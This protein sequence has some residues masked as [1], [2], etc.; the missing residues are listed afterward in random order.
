T[1]SIIALYDN[2]GA[3]GKLSL[4]E[5]MLAAN[6]TANGSSPD[7]IEFNIPTSDTGYNK[8]GL[9]VFTI[10]PTSALPT[11]TNAVII[12]GT[13]Q[14]QYLSSP[15]I[16]IDGSNAGANAD[17][18]SISS[19]GGGTT[20][21]GFA[22]NGY[23]SGYGIT[24]TTAGLNDIEANYIGIRATG[25]DSV[26]GAIGWWQ[27]ESNATNP[28]TGLT[29]TWVGTASYATGQVGSAMSFNGSSYIN[30][31]NQGN[32]ASS[33]VTLEAWVYATQF[34]TWD[35]VIAAGNNSAATNAYWFGLNSGKATF[36]TN[37]TGSGQTISQ[38]ASALSLNQWYHL[39]GIDDGTTRSLYVNGS[40]VD[41]DAVSGSLVYS[42][43]SPLLI[44]ADFDFG[45]AAVQFNGLIDEAAIYG[46]ALSTTELT[47]NYNAGLTGKSPAKISLMGNWQGE[48][49]ATDSRGLN[50]GTLTNGATTTTAGKIG[51]AF[52]LDGVNDYVDLGAMNGMVLNDFTASAW[53]YVDAAT[54]TGQRR[55]ISWDDVSTPGADGRE[56]FS[57]K[58]SDGSNLPDFTIMAG[59]TFTTVTGSALTTGWHQLVGTRSGANLAFYIDGVLAGSSSSA[60]TSAISPEAHMVLGQVS[61]EFSGEFLNGKVDEAML[62]TRA[63]TA[64]DVA[65]LY[66]SQSR[67]TDT[68]VD[69]PIASYKAEG[70]GNDFQSTHEGTASGGVTYTPGITGQG[71]EFDGTGKIS[72]PDSAVFNAGAALSVSAWVNPDAIGTS[73]EIVAQWNANTGQRGFLMR[74]NATGNAEF[75]I[76]RTGGVDYTSAVSSVA[77]TANHWSLLTG[78]Y[79]GTNIR[80]YVDGVLRGTTA[81]A[82]TM[83]NSTDPVLIGDSN[84]N[85]K[86]PFD[87]TIDEV[88]IYNRV[89]SAAEITSMYDAV[90]QS[91][92]GNQMG[93]VLSNSS[94]NTIGG[95]TLAERNV[96]SGNNAHGVYISGNGIPD[97]TVSWWKADGNANDSVGSNNGTLTNGATVVAGGVRGSSF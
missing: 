28:I 46:R 24:A 9:G 92:V 96:I 16:E 76:S 5:A 93:V 54:N 48:G 60:N 42:N 66:A 2:L 41:S 79:D 22:I 94:G 81:Y 25:G 62:L 8:S 33:I 32:Y 73:R 83:F 51:S 61:P 47:T 84:S 30:L 20:I 37:H 53:V 70:N 71:F 13:S 19:T 14:S 40:L 58:S 1:T 50:N 39:V 52:S 74:I 88:A 21:R 89:L 75:F 18:F 78:T 11:I 87:G 64:T 38:G 23:A 26:E 34:D 45:S 67:D 27:G 12:D 82:G 29:G 72:I 91:S 97:S 31:G 4:R 69:T 65:S 17:G 36:V 44:G 57:L 95:T 35:T 43:A 80:I 7:R 55:V 68:F 3:D 63:L 6:N 86:N 15:V 90:A 49:D 59:G 56:L 77:L 85:S 10:Q